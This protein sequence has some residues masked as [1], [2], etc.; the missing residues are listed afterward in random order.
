MA[1]I[2]ICIFLL[3]TG[4]Y[5]SIYLKTIDYTDTTIRGFLQ[6]APQ[7][8]LLFAAIITMRRWQKKEDGNMG[9]L[10]TSPV[11]DVDVCLGKFLAA[12]E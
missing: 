4:T 7:L 5:F 10:L 9:V 6:Y 2:V 3:V 12:S 11:R 8:L 1:Y